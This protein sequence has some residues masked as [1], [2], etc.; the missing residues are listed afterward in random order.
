MAGLQLGNPPPA[1]DQLALK[2]NATAFVLP[3]YETVTVPRTVFPLAVFGTLIAQAAPPGMIRPENV[4]KP[5]GDEDPMGHSVK[6]LA[7][8]GWP[9]NLYGSYVDKNE[10]QSDPYP[11]GTFRYRYDLSRSS[12]K[13]LA[14]LCIA[15]LIFFG[16]AIVLERHIRTKNNLTPS[17]EGTQA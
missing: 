9:C 3:R 16:T 10:E 11:D 12:L 6:I 1:P 17:R 5:Y 8:V 7:P 14:N 4:F 13:Y 15:A 2:E